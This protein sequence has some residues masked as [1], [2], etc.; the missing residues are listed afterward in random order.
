VTTRRRCRPQLIRGSGHLPIAGR[1]TYGNREREGGRV[2]LFDGEPEGDPRW[3]FDV[4][5]R[6]G[7]GRFG[8]PPGRYTLW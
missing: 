6:D 4:Q 8:G 1:P 3:S 5:F 7:I 2:L